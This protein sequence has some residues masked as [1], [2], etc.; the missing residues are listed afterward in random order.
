MRTYPSP[1]YSGTSEG[2]SL[3][4][5]LVPLDSALDSTGV[6]LVSPTLGSRLYINS[7]SLSYQG[8]FS[9]TV[10]PTDPDRYS[11]GVNSGGRTIGVFAVPRNS[12]PALVDV[13]FSAVFD[14]LDAEI[15]GLCT[16][17]W[18]SSAPADF[19]TTGG[20]C[21]VIYGEL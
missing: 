11:L 21:S 15:D 5:A 19:T 8:S 12:A 20:W 7:I 16:L 10:A 9:G 2:L 4:S 14:L 1:L 17:Q 13:S 6:S 18:I 3:L